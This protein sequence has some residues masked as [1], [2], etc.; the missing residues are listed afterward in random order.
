M[1]V[2]RDDERWTA[3]PLL[4]S[5]DGAAASR[6]HARGRTGRWVAAGA[7]VGAIALVLVAALALTDP[8]RRRG[9]AASDAAPARRSATRA[10][11][12][13][14][15]TLGRTSSSDANDDGRAG[16]L[17]VRRR[18]SPP[19]DAPLAAA[20]VVP[21]APRVGDANEMVTLVDLDDLDEETGEKSE[22]QRG[23]RKG[24][25]RWLKPSTIEAHVHAA[26]DE[27]TN[28]FLDELPT[29]VPAHAIAEVKWAKFHEATDRVLPPADVGSYAGEEIDWTVVREKKAAAA[30]AAES[31]AKR[32]ERIRLIVEN[33]RLAER[34]RMDAAYG[35]EAPSGS[36][37]LAPICLA[38]V[39]SVVV[40]AVLLVR[41]RGDD[42]RGRVYDGREEGAID[43]EK[44][45]SRE[46]EMGKDDRLLR[47][48]EGDS[49]RSG[50][51][52]TDVLE[53]ASDR[54]SDAERGEGAR[55]ERGAVTHGGGGGETNNRRS[56]DGA[57]SSSVADSHSFADDS[58]SYGLSNFPSYGATRSSAAN[59]RG[60]M[61]AGFGS[62][63]TAMDRLIDDSRSD[64]APSEAPSTVFE[65]NPPRWMARM[66]GA[67]ESGNTVT[68][69]APEE[70]NT[71]DARGNSSRGESVFSAAD[72]SDAEA[73]ANA[74]RHG[75][76]SYP[77]PRGKQ[78][79]P[80]QTPGRPRSSS[81]A[82]AVATSAHASAF[83]APPPPHLQSRSAGGGG[84]AAAAG[85]GKPPR[86]PFGAGHAMAGAG[87]P[88]PPDRPPRIVKSTTRF[89]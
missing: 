8:A 60:M 1:R 84:G 56:M 61:S 81:N 69:G 28:E 63:N 23:W 54:A 62:R 70:G 87:R 13:H 86:T 40:I 80:G 71:V 42:G 35:S 16:Y 30:G 50:G 18:A 7:A 9:G 6:R 37:I 3:V 10:N 72:F 33:E 57:E 12:A 73:Y 22:A 21:G 29:R 89:L 46:G 68:A 88:V 31:P 5:D 34:A 65:I 49:R 38:V 4:A 79:V 77:Y 58:R 19:R 25:E 45:S 83:A 66:F 75:T 51:S 2:S 43:R 15:A 24:D 32:N 41:N 44:G 26:D 64:V 48:S 74:M 11:A 85:G 17:A 47:G 27:L 36:F 59:L 55:D 39:S 76:K 53:G 67:R 78:I 14:A 52:E 20:R 82:V